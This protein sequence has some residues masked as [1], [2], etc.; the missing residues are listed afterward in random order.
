MIELLS[1]AG[2]YE[3][4]VAA[5]NSGADAVYLGAKM[6]N[7]RMG[8]GNFDEDEF[9]RAADF[10]HER[11]R[12]MYVTVNTLVKQS[13][14]DGLYALSRLMQRAGA[15]AAIVQDLGVAD[16]FKEM[17]P[18]LELHASTQM[19]I[20]NRQGVDFLRDFGFSRAV[21]A[22][23]M[24]YREVA[25]CAGQGVDIEVFAHGALCVSC[26][27]QCLFSSIVGGR[28]GNRG[29]CAQ[30]CRTRYSMSG[31]ADAEGY[32]LSTRDLCAIGDLPALK[33]AGVGCIKIEGRLKRP[34]YVAIVTGIYRRALDNPGN[35]VPD[36]DIDALARV[37]NRGGFTRGYG[38]GSDDSD[39]I[40]SGAPNHRGVPAGTAAGRGSALLS[41]RVHSGDGLVIRG[42][43]G[44]ERAVRG[45][46]GEAGERVRLPEMRAGDEL[47]LVSDAA[48]LA[49][50]REII[51]GNR[52]DIEI[53]M[54]LRANVGEKAKLTV[55]DGARSIEA[56][57]CQPLERANKPAD[58]DRTRSQLI[59]TGGT[60]YIAGEVS[61]EIAPD[62]FLPVSLVNDMR[63]RALDA[64]RLERIAAA[65]CELGP[66]PASREERDVPLP[67]RAFE[68]SVQSRDVN[69]LRSALSAGADR[70]IF[71]P[72]DVTRAGLAAAAARLDGIEFYVSLPDTLTG[73]GLDLLNRWTLE[74]RGVRGVIYNNPAHIS[75]TWPGE[76]QAGTGLNI[77][78]RR[79]LGALI[80]RG[81]S[82]YSPSLELNS[83]E[84]LDIDRAGNGRELV[85][86]GAIPLMILR[87]CPLRA[88]LGGRHDSCNRCGAADGRGGISGAVF[89]D[90]TGAKFRFDRL[91]APGGCIVRLINGDVLMPLRRADKLPPADGWRLIIGGEDPSRTAQI[92]AAYRRAA[93][94][95]IDISPFEGMNTTSGHYFRGV[96]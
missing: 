67:A 56:E 69:V 90:R 64:L 89:T 79:A 68:L 71:E 87:H 63:R 55:S 32:L 14:I 4:L 86:Y 37:F 70:A 73:A 6:F 11:G 57:S 48:Q 35:P 2:S 18:G 96:E 62:A 52:Q 49:S 43:E 44:E 74:T 25:E 84:I 91:A 75:L 28:S 16:S 40:F 76:A 8:A 23:E 1:P 65:R 31:P 20:H 9:L 82:R 93:N 81:I 30:P 41:R 85:V 12:R 53:T 33:E 59:K 13:E 78:N 29:R 7:A 46:S 83:R 50:A 77:F 61:L 60:P 58:P 17:L 10:L 24:N 94:G 21:L 27:G 3:S 5:V 22:R 39:L 92:V 47:Y 80:S 34:E 42:V 38:P 54:A 36:T 45:I 15:D 51:A 88:R 66:I 26:S 19:A 95:D 72:E